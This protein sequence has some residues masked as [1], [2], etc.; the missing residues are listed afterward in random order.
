M[1]RHLDDAVIRGAAYRGDSEIVYGLV[2]AKWP[3]GGMHSIS[4]EMKSYVRP[5]IAIVQASL[6]WH[7]ILRNSRFTGMDYLGPEGDISE[8]LTGPGMR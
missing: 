3:E 7:K 8:L 5:Q 6:F 4:E 1:A 2:K